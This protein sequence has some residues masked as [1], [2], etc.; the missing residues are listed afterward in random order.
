ME[1]VWAIPVNENP[2]IVVMIV[3]VA[4]DV[5]TLIAKQNLLVR[6]SC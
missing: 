4:A 1:N 6:A 3:S 2:G 5:R